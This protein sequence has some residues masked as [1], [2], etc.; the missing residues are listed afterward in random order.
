MVDVKQD[1]SD[2]PVDMEEWRELLRQARQM[3]TAYGVIQSIHGQLSLDAITEGIVHNLVEIG[4]LSGATISIDASF[5]TLHVK[6]SADA[7]EFLEPAKQF[8]V[9]ARG[10]EVGSLTVHMAGGDEAELIELVDYVLPT[11]WMSIDNAISFAEV[12]DFKRTLEEKVVER[13]AQ[14][15][16]ANEQLVHAKAARDRFFANIN[17]EI[18][19]PLTLIQLAS[20]AIT[21]SGES[22]S[23]NTQQKLD[24]INGSTRRL[25]HLVNSLLLLAAGDEGK[26]RVRPAPCDVARC[27]QR[28]T[29]NWATAA[30]K[31]HIEIV[32]VGPQQCAS[33]MDE[34]ALET[35]VGN[36]VSNAVK[37]TPPGGKITVTLSSTD[38]AVTIGVR[39]TGPG[40][41]PEF[42]PKLFGRFERSTGAATRGVRGT[43]IGLALSKELVDLQHGSIRVERHEDPRGTTFEV[44]LPRRQVVA[45]VLPS[46]EPQPSVREELGTPTVDTGAALR[47][48]EAREP[49]ATIVL[50]EDDPG[51]SQHITEVLSTRYRVLAAPNGKAALALAAEHLPDLLVTDLEMPEMNGLELTREFLALQGTA[52]SPVLIVSAHA[53]LGERLAGFEAGAVDYVVKP[54]SADE[55]LARIRSQ[56][57]IRKL[58]L[59]LHESQKLAAMG[60]LS[61]GLAHE[62]R[63]PANAL[64]NALQPLLASVPA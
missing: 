16:E 57:A 45:A 19:T 11:I 10:V 15:A 47:A 44:T 52:L 53:G 36:F 60:M 14:L 20:D 21:R 62:L 51:L 3:Q 49:E 1:D 35:I 8:A 64:V 30:Q 39:D 2:L 50:A 24:E 31:G 28:L 33:V 48:A 13:T 38:D 12:L 23:G 55:L 25:L 63:N 54:F 42:I 7:G 6:S 43:G 59:K 4:G 32:F 61:A 58:A 18:R 17:H 27:V 26:L 56:L 29:R 34:A 22:L 41:E 9:F 46:E 40:I 5:E 37:F